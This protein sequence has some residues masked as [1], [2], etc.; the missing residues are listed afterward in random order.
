MAYML[1]SNRS[2][3]RIR[4][5]RSPD[6]R[7]LGGPCTATI[8]GGQSNMPMRGIGP[9]SPV[10]AVWRVADLQSQYVNSPS[11]LLPRSISATIS[12]FS[13]SRLLLNSCLLF[14]GLCALVD[15][16]LGPKRC[17]R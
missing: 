10:W 7:Q 14:R 17:L 9:Q 2:L 4:L 8:L 16:V 11:H 5:N 12:V 6:V 1:H 15:F 13:V 3:P